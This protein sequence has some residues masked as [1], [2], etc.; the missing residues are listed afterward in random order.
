VREF[1]V[2]ELQRHKSSVVHKSRTIKKCRIAATAWYYV[3][4][5]L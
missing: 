4:W 3:L 5:Q 2:K 1:T